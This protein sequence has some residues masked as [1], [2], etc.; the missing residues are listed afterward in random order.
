MQGKHFNNSRV[1][2]KSGS[3]WFENKLIAQFL[4]ISFLLTQ[5]FYLSF[6]HA[7]P[8]GGSVV[9]GSGSISQSNLT[10]TINQTTQNL[11]INWQSFDV[12]TNERVE[13]IQRN[14]SS[15]A[16][17][18]ILSNNGSVIQ[19]QI[20]ANGQVILVN[21]NGVFFSSTATVNV[22][23]LIASSL[24]MTPSDFMNGNYIFL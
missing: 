6:L 2:F 18:R 14:T 8:V 11:A 12:K 3:V 21:P 10:T 22:G 1:S 4:T 15:I 13:F 19:G 16:L 23:G 20:D 7:A 17:N 5:P 9:G 24:D